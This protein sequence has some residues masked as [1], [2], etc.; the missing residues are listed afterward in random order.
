MKTIAKGFLLILALLGCVQIFELF[1]S[2]VSAETH[3]TIRPQ[4]KYYIRLEGDEKDK[5]QIL[6]IDENLHA[7][8]IS[9]DRSLILNQTKNE[10]SYSVSVL[11]DSEKIRTW[12]DDGDG[13][14][15]RRIREPL[16]YFEIEE[17]ARYKILEEPN[18]S[19]IN[20]TDITKK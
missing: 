14:T 3:I 2:A 16:K 11:T 1:R 8:F 18:F 19:W 12:D 13:I 15:D 7:V 17:E 5:A 10:F 9:G 6:S 20:Q 4:E